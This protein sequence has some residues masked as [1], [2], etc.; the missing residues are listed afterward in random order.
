MSGT[1]STKED[2]S[3]KG[4]STRAQSHLSV[5]L[6][7]SITHNILIQS[8]S[9]QMKMRTIHIEAKSAIFACKVILLKSCLSNRPCRV[10]REVTCQTMLRQRVSEGKTRLRRW[11]HE[12]DRFLAKS[13]LTLHSLRSGLGLLRILIVEVTIQVD[14]E[15]GEVSQ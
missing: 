13:L 1:A 10:L 4:T 2:S 7:T 3:M 15:Y 9:G 12:F 11:E 14:F 6:S 8:Y 5:N